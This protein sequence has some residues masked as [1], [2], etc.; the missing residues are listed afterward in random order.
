[1]SHVDF[2]ESGDLGGYGVPDGK[3]WFRLDY[4]IPRTFR[5]HYKQITCPT[6]TKST[7]EQ[8]EELRRLLD[9]QD[10]QRREERELERML[11]AAR[12]DAE[13]QI[14]RQ[15]AAVSAAVKST[16]AAELAAIFKRFT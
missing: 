16:P 11:S 15:I 8:M 12:H 1:M 7:A 10:R 4:D 9:E 6:T 14:E 3:G 13:Q 2:S 5:P